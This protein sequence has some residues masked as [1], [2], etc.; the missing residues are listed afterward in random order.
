LENNELGRSF[1]VKPPTMIEAQDLRQRIKGQAGGHPIPNWAHLAEG[2]LDRGLAIHRVRNAIHIPM[3][4]VVIASDGSV[5]YQSVEEALYG[6]PTLAGLPY[7]TMVDGRPIMAVPSDV[8]GFD[9]GTIFCAAGGPLNYT[10]FLLDCLTT[11]LAIDQKGLTV[12]YSPLMPSGLKKWHYD[13]LNRMNTKGS[14]IEISQPLVC[15]NDLLYASP[16]AHYLVYPGQLLC[17]LK[18]RVGGNA[19]VAKRRVYLSRLGDKKREMINEAML[20]RALEKRGFIIVKPETL[21]VEQQIELM[22]ETSIVAGAVGAA[23][24]NCLFMPYASRVI[25]IQPSNYVQSFVRSMCDVLGMEW[26]PF[27]C[28]SPL[29]E[30]KILIEGEERFGTFSFQLPLDEFLSFLDKVALVSPQ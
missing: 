27:F 11:L 7:V 8:V 24:G 20:E 14:C 13:L 3:L 18:E 17:D 26:Y 22:A 5:L 2:R 6:T 30:H 1:I 25:E 19:A 15:V 23:L 16:M 28:E 29:E 9:R 10:H 21:S 12:D 4:G